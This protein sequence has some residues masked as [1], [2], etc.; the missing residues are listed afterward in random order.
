MA[1]SIRGTWRIQS[2]L[3]TATNFACML[4]MVFAMEIDSAV[5]NPNLSRAC[6][7]G[8]TC[9]RHKPTHKPDCA[10]RKCAPRMP[11]K[12]NWRPPKR[13]DRC[14]CGHVEARHD[15]LGCKVCAE[16]G[17]AK[18]CLAFRNSLQPHKPQDNTFAREVQ[19]AGFISHREEI[20][21]CSLCWTPVKI[22]FLHSV[23]CVINA[24]AHNQLCS[25]R[26]GKSKDRSSPNRTKE[27]G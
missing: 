1:A 23:S 5:S 25:K 22:G 2:E 21:T 20:A 3:N 13:T 18:L 10:C 15:K 9:K 14:M 11:I 6:K 19:R 8:C 17:K 26:H 24:R 27:V 4:L 16:A 12:R 7:P